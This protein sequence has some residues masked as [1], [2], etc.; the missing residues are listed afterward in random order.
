MDWICG[1]FCVR[2]DDTARL[3]RHRAGFM[4]RS[5]RVLG[6]KQDNGLHRNCLY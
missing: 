2:Y 1:V 6:T 4:Q 3:H 5:S